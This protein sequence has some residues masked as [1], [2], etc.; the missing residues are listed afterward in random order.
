MRGEE[1]EKLNELPIGFVVEDLTSITLGLR[2]ASLCYLRDLNLLALETKNKKFTELALTLSKLAEDLLAVG[3]G[4]TLRD[5]VKYP[6]D[7]VENL[8]KINLREIKDSLFEVA[9]GI[10]NR[11][12][13]QIESKIGE[14]LKSRDLRLSLVCFPKIGYTGEGVFLSPAYLS[15]E[16]L[17]VGYE[18]EIY[19]H[20][21]DIGNKVERIKDLRREILNELNGVLATKAS[22]NY[23]REIESLTGEILAIPACCRKAFIESRRKA[24]EY[25]LGKDEEVL[26]SNTVSLYDFTPVQFRSHENLIA[27]ELRE[28]GAY[29]FVLEKCAI[30]GKIKLKA[31]LDSC[32]EKLPDI[33]YSLWSQDVFPCSVKC[34]ASTNMGISMDALLP[35][36]LKIAYRLLR[37]NEILRMMYEDSK[38]HL[39]KMGLT[40]EVL[41]RIK[42]VYGINLLRL[43]NKLL[44]LDFG[45]YDYQSIRNLT[46]KELRSYTGCLKAFS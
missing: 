14:I 17:T 10:E 18:I 44:N 28:N 27:K 1:L 11:Y 29:D 30:S 45:E 13:Q 46:L 5:V 19:V 34:K 38:L 43:R 23:A 4:K 2:K 22:I 21:P 20:K 6:R 24:H 8:Q 32:A 40:K 15:P 31:L 37:L 33:F 3:Y 41:R 12:F 9:A 35:N 16:Y 36:R 26:K 39:L 25:L 7:V 42:E